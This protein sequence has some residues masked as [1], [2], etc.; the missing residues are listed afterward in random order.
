[1][2]KEHFLVDADDEPEV[3]NALQEVGFD[4]EPSASPVGKYDVV[5]A[6]DE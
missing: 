4:V 5:R 1:M 3:I 6:N 2:V